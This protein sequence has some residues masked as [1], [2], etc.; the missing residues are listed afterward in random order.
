[1][2][3]TFK[4]RQYK[5]GPVMTVTPTLAGLGLAH[6]AVAT[7]A[8]GATFLWQVWAIKNERFGKFNEIRMIDLHGKIQ[9]ETVV[10]HD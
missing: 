7:G 10:R 8:R 5:L 2:T 9:T 3:T 4:G 1:M 6:Q